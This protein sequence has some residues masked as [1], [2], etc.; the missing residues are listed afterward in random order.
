MTVGRLAIT[1][2]SEGLA[3]SLSSVEVVKEELLFVGYF[4]PEM[5]AAI[6]LETSPS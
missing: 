1:G 5:E 2:F 4:G 6:S 3:P